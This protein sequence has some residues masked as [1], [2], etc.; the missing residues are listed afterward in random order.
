MLEKKTSNMIRNAKRK[1][2]RDLVI[3]ED[4][5]NRKFT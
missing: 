2:E 1:M 3:C 5:N 4:K